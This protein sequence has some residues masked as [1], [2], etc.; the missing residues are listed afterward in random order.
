[1]RTRKVP[2]AATAE[3]VMQKLFRVQISTP[4][5]TLAEESWLTRRQ[6]RYFYKPATAAR[7]RGQLR[8]SEGCRRC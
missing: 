1:M 8:A 2:T 7:L 6:D 4:R 3:E 5:H